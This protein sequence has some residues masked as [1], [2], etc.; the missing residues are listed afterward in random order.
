MLA[1]AEDDFQRALY[2]LESELNQL[3]AKLQV[4]LSEWTGDAKAAYEAA[5][6]QWRAAAANM[7]NNL[8]WLHGV[9]RTARLN[10]VSSRT[11][12]LGM[13]KGHG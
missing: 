6:A 1:S 2:A 4:S 8:A 9:V 3:D 7:V 11:T 10:F 12:N 13:W 5:H